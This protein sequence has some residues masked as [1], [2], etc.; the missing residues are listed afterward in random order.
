MP[1]T[2]VQCRNAKP[3][4]KPIKISDGGGLFLLVQ[5][6]GG[7]LW[8]LA[9]RF[10]GKQKTLALGA[11]PIVSLKDARGRRDEAKELLARGI[12]PS[13]EKKAEKRRAKLAAENSFEAVA[14]EWFDARRPGLAPSYASRIWSRLEGDIFPAIGQR[15]IAAIE[16]PELLE[17]IRKIERRGAIILAKRTL[18]VCGQIFRFAIAS[19][20]A[21]RD[22]SQDL[23]GALRSAG[24]CKRRAAMKAEN[25][26]GFM[27]ALDSYEG[28]RQ[29]ALAL[30]LIVHTFLR[31][32]EVRFGR[33]EEIDWQAALWR[34]PAE[35]MKMRG[36]HLVP[37]TL[38][39]L[40][41]L[42]ELK[43]LAGNSPMILPAPTK[44]GVISQNTLIYAL[45]RM[46]YHSRATVHS[47]R[48]T[49]STALNEHG[50]N[51][52]W[53][54][55][56]LAHADRSVRARYNAA[57]WLADRRRMM[58][59]WSE[60]LSEMTSSSAQD[61]VMQSAGCSAAPP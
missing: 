28:E 31:T 46:G 3:A 15:P 22:P 2:D 29:T 41:I 9:Y 26:P 12:D 39:V 21:T 1:L 58:E 40:A 61:R 6:T 48:G 19:G 16:P 45:Y 52:D 60:R 44:A 50:F 36:E 42:Q 33:W 7:K 34:I 24:P 20:R 49:A 59:W 54:E 11:Y 38:P 43:A 8:R 30:K 53:I 18:Q 37:L 57:E 35:R 32:N 10:A 13:E 55:R 4:E 25:L 51:R 56:Q 47:F 5:P 27:K 17:T 23:R 14:R